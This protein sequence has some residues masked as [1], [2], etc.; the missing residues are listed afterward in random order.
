MA[1]PNLQMLRATLRFS[2]YGGTE[3]KTLYT[4]PKLESLGC[5]QRLRQTAPYSLF[6]L[7]VCSM[8][9]LVAA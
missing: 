5:R 9:N 6:I 4:S 3:T 7:T 8:S 1:I 2:K